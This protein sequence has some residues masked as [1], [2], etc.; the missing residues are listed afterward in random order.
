MHTGSRPPQQCDSNGVQLNM[1]V[2]RRDFLKTAGIGAAALGF[3]GWLRASEPAGGLP[4][5]I[6]ILCD[7]LGYGDIKCLNG[8]GKIPTPNVDKL[9]A[10]GMVFTDAHSGSSVCTPTR[11]GV[12]TGR[13]C[14]RT[15]LQSGVLGGFSPPLIDRQRMTVATLLKQKGYRT[16]C[17]GKWH[18][19]MDIPKDSANVKVGEGPTTRGFDYYYGI[20]ASLDM[21]PF[22]FI[23]DDHFTQAPTAKKTWVRQGPAAPDFEAVEVLPSLTRK[24]VDYIDSN[25]G[26]AK[27]GKP[28]FI[29]LPLNSPHAPI[30]PIKKWQGMSGLGTYAD[31]VM[32]TDSSVGEIMAALDRNGLAGNTLLIFTSDNG[33]SPVANIGELEKKGHHPNY[34]FR[35]HKADI[36]DGGHRI[37]FICRWPGKIKPGTRSDQLICLTDLMATCAAIVDAKLPPNAGEDS[38]SILAAL[39]GSDK[40]PLR[41]AVVHHSISGR[42]SIRQGK[43]KLEL[44]GGSG[45]WSQP[46]D[47]AARAKGLPEV[48]LYDMSRDVVEKVNVQDKNANVVEQLTRLLEKYVAEGR[49]TP[50]APQKNDT[51]VQIWKNQRKAEGKGGR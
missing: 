49:S 46:D 23:E 25:A 42:F 41:E 2:S 20:S 9:A 48:Q 24:T 18:L 15:S 51:Q 35:G 5:I 30:L 43:W 32:Q 50:G 7:D 45:G 29:Y 22:A 16:A 19:G 39:T 38:V 6:Y 28:F 10:E 21:P 37:P 33:C 47:G 44:C 26:A 27:S 14:W 17:I 11:Y 13:Y 4:N 34:I 8:G 3:S 31:F 1:N 36:W 12:L 40:E